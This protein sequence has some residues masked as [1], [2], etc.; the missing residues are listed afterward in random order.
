MEH[1]EYE[2]QMLTPNITRPGLRWKPVA[3]RGTRHDA[4][5]LMEDIRESLA[6]SGI[7]RNAAATWAMT[8]LRGV[9]VIIADKY[10]ESFHLEP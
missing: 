6:D 7:P 2:V 1:A 5:S 9:E 10:G 4:A 8:H 3:V